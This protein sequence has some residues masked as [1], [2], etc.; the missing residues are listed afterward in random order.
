MNKKEAIKLLD[1][2]DKC[3][4]GGEPPEKSLDE[5]GIKDIPIAYSAEFHNQLILGMQ[6]MLKHIYQIP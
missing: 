3:L 4:L 2:L 6:V 1:D 5:L